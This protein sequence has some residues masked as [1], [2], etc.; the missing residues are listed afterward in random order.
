M[1]VV[2]VARLF[3]TLKPDSS[4]CIHE[5]D[6]NFWCYFTVLLG[7]GTAITYKSSHARLMVNIFTYRRTGDYWLRNKFMSI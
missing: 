6:V 5:P 3:P 7:L 1:V 2:V 4:L